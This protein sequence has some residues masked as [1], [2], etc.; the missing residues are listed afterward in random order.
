MPFA[1]TQAVLRKVLPDWVFEKLYRAATSVY[2]TKQ[3]IADWFYYHK[4]PTDVDER[5]MIDMLQ[6]VRPYTMVLIVFIMPI[7]PISKAIAEVI[8]AIAPA[9][10]MRVSVLTKSSV[11]MANSRS[12]MASI[13]CTAGC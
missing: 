8:Q 13:C 2:Y 12:S 5:V 9:R 1:R 11:G 10:R 3:R 4:L 7:A 6:D